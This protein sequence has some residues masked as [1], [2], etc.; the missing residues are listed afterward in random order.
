MMSAHKTVVVTV[1]GEPK[2]GKSKVV[3]AITPV[4]KAL[5]GVLAVTVLLVIF[6]SVLSRSFAQR[7]VYSGRTRDSLSETFKA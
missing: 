6:I 3:Q 1:S 4:L 5:S 2:A 7:T